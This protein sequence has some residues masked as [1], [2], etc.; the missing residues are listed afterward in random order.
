MGR[1]GQICGQK[2]DTSKKWV[3][4]EHQETGFYPSKRVEILVVEI[5][6]TEKTTVKI[7]AL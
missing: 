5:R 2:F 3:K 1:A 6:R 4:V 7:A